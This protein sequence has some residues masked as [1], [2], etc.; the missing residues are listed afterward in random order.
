MDV[1]VDEIEV[2][3][4]HNLVTDEPEDCPHKVGMR[5]RQGTLCLAVGTLGDQAG[6]HTHRRRTE[7]ASKVIHQLAERAFVL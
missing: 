4:L 6:D 3:C 5:P 1:V 2:V 7:V